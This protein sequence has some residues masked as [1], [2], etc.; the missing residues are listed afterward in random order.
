MKAKVV[1]FSTFTWV[2]SLN[3][4]DEYNLSVT[5]TDGFL[6]TWT[7]ADEAQKVADEI[8]TR[9]SAAS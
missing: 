7:T 2:V 9:L 4:G 5:T 8:N 1:K 3:C 6:R